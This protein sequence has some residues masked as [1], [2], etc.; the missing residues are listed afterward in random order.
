MSVGRTLDMTK[1]HPTRLLLRFAMPIFLGNLL[2][3]CY[4]LVDTAL[5]GHMLGD[6]A[7]SEIGR[8]S[9]REAVWRCWSVVFGAAASGSGCA[10]R[11]AGWWCW[12]PAWRRC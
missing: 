4:N 5:A 10:V 6:A 12:A 11:F 7:L 8:A 1:G 3:Q 2:Q 9:C